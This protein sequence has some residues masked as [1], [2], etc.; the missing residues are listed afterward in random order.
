MKGREI[1]IS[2]LTMLHYPSLISQWDSREIPIYLKDAS[3]NNHTG[4]I[5]TMKSVW[6]YNPV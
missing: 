6:N 1:C 4:F 5:T 3:K 2:V